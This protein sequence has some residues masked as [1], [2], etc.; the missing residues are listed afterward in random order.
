MRVAVSGSSGLIGTALSEALR[1]GGHEAVR[2][3]RGSPHPPDVGWDP[4][5]GVVDGDGLAGIDA[6]VNLSGAGI[7]D[8]RWTPA[9]R[10]LLVSSRVDSTALLCRAVSRLDP[11]PQVLLNASAVGV[12]GDR[13]D[14]VLTESSAPGSGFLAGLCQEWE[15]ATHPAAEAGI[16]TVHLR[17]GVV[18]SARGGAL[19]RQLPLFRLGLGGRLGPGRQWMSWVSLEDEVGAILFLLA[20]GEVS[21][22][23]NVVAPEPVRNDLF[24][25]ALARALHRPALL[26]V[27]A[28]AL[29]LAL[30][31]GLADEAILA[32]QR[33]VPAALKAAGYRFHHDEVDSALRAALAH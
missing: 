12:Y 30:G 9:R 10:A 17:S 14:E 4:G 3:V 5:A 26:A 27:P 25:S 22:P 29:R 24:T 16:R 20:H 2:L 18:L 19:A 33:V 6:V 1:Q 28:P 32:S 7:G 21:G 11:P 23:V 15:Q 8:R 13:G 31:R